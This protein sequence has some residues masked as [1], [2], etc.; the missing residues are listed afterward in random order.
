MASKFKPGDIY[1]VKCTP[2][3]RQYGLH[4]GGAGITEQDSRIW[5]KEVGT[6]CVHQG[7]G[8]QCK[9]L[10]FSRGRTILLETQ[11]SDSE[12]WE[13]DNDEILNQVIREKI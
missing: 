7:N 3:L 2:S 12:N 10:E 8:W 1:R 5:P 11:Y 6:V 13:S 9:R 4:C